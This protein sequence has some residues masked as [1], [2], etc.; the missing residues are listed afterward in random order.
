MNV[1]AFYVSIMLTENFSL[2]VNLW[3]WHLGDWNCNSGPCYLCN[4]FSIIKRIIAVPVTLFYLG[5]RIGMNSGCQERPPFLGC[6]T[7]GW[8]QKHKF[9]FFHFPFPISLWFFTLSSRL[10]FL[11]QCYDLSMW[12]SS[13]ISPLSRCSFCQ[14]V[15]NL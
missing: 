13:H 8:T 7:A 15:W 9:Y 5:C 12:S 2:Y 1:N 11:L 10:P 6:S 14:I 3:L 4:R